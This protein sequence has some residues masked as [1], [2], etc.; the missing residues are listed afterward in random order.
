MAKPN[1]NET[2]TYSVSRS[3][4]DRSRWQL[5]RT[6]PD[7]QSAL[8]SSSKTR[9]ARER[10]RAQLAQLHI[11]GNGAPFTTSGITGPN[12]ST[13]IDLT[14]PPDIAA[15]SAREAL[16]EAR[17]RSILLQDDETVLADSEGRPTGK[18]VRR[19]RA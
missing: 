15:G 14:L 17:R 19:P 10:R 4:Y 9:E 5:T 6:W 7:P 11:P 8:T 1:P 12:A 16:D 18:I 13:S 2:G 3:P